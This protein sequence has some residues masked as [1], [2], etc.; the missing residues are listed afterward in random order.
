MACRIYFFDADG[1]EIPTGN[2]GKPYA[3]LGS[4]LTTDGDLACM[5]DGA[6]ARDTRG[7]ISRTELSVRAFNGPE[8]FLTIANFP[9]RDRVLCKAWNPGRTEWFWLVAGPTTVVQTITG[10]YTGRGDRM[11]V[12]EAYHA[13]GY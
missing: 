10:S 5:S 11:S 4:A 9:G 2:N 3:W 7:R 8:E 6:I 1:R 13:S 12:A